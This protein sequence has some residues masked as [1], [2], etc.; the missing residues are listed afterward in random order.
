MLKSLKKKK[1]SCYSGT[2]KC[3][4]RSVPLSLTLTHISVSSVCSVD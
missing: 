3:D 4:K 2:V 1:E